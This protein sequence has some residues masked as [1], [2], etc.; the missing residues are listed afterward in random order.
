[1]TT[2]MRTLPI[3]DWL[4]LKTIDI[5][6]M[7][8]HVIRLFV[9]DV[10]KNRIN[11]EQISHYC[12]RL[13]SIRQ[14]A[15]VIDWQMFIHCLSESQWSMFLSFHTRDKIQMVNDD[16]HVNLDS[17]SWFIVIWYDRLASSFDMHNDMKKRIG[18]TFFY[19]FVH[20]RTV[21]R[22]YGTYCLH[23]PRVF[24]I[25][26]QSQWI[27]TLNFHWRIRFECST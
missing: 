24:F 23:I 16:T 19:S 8:L 20:V 5:L 2:V 12:V 15:K 17:F 22:L 10:F 9:I 13:R 26:E 7:I 4:C 27:M 18:I 11:H 1:M 21:T 14:V 6:D 25:V 3:D